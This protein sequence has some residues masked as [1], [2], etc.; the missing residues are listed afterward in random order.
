MHGGMEEDRV[1][2]REGSEVRSLRG[3]IL[4]DGPTDFVRVQRR[5]GIVEIARSGIIKIERGQGDKGNGRADR[6]TN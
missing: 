2:Y 5:T 1:V 6:T 4:E 3:H